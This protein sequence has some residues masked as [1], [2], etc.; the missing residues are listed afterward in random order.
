M[1]DASEPALEEGDPGRGGG[2]SRLPL[3]ALIVVVLVF[4][5]FA[6]A[7]AIN[8]QPWQ[9][10]DEP[11]HFENIE[12]LV[13][14]HWYGFDPNCRTSST[15]GV[16]DAFL[17]CTGLESHQAPLYYLLMAGWQR[18]LGIP[19]HTLPKSWAALTSAH[20]ILRDRGLLLWLRFGNIA[21]GALTVVVSYLAARLATRDRWTP[22][23]AAAVVAFLPQFLIHAAYVTNDNLVNLLGAVL[24][25]CGLQF[26][27]CKTSAWM[28]A[29][30]VTF[31]LMLTTKL[32][33]IPMGLVLVALVVVVS[34]VSR[35][36]RVLLL[37]TGAGSALAVSIGYLISNWVRYGDPLASRESS[38]YLVHVSGLGTGV[39][40]PYVVT[41]PARLVFYDVGRKLIATFWYNSWWGEVSWPMPINLLI[42]CGVIAVLLGL[43]GQSLS[44]RP[45]AL[46]GVI[47]V[48]SFACVWVVA[49][50]TASYS[51]RLALVGVSALG[52]LVAL[53]L[54]RWSLPVRWLLPLA[55]LTGVF[56]ALRYDILGT[57]W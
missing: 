19:P 17:A 52:T 13:S 35:R 30:G 21:L 37:V 34:D 27:R 26:V 24:T 42:T 54:Q 12:T 56:V 4:V 22:V 14:G 39:N 3:V 1:V 46:L 44:R 53:G 43:L 47:A 18:V 49:F 38:A 51:A 33:T 7:V 2:R 23:I 29:C 50:Q 31:G 36:R 40:V 57:H 45:L 55:E 10:A 5:A 48:L 9:G 8:T 11:G 16:Q 28:I 20:A 32:S 15:T 41:D 25:Y 6:A